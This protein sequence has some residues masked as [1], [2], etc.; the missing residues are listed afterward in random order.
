MQDI[1]SISTGVFSTVIVTIFCN[2]FFLTNVIFIGNN[3]NFISI[4][5]HL[6][7]FILFILFIS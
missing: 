4:S 5:F 7:K 1:S 2:Y 6:Q 3:E